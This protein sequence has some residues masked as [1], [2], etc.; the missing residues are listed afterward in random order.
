MKTVLITVALFA[1]SSCKAPTPSHID[2]VA[3]ESY[4]VECATDWAESVVTGD[5]SRR[6]VYFANEFQ[7]TG[8][9]GVRYDRAA[10][11]QDHDPSTVYASNVIGPIDVRF[12]GSTA[13]AYGEETWT[14]V[15]GETGRWI[16]T[17]IWL[18]RD[19]EWQIIAAQD[20]EIRVAQ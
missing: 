18:H 5:M 2:E 12:F 17:D 20:N 13:I 7:G 15:N 6:R 4:I 10:V 16:W 3:A 8:I 1:A 19:G 14:K 11:T 9:D